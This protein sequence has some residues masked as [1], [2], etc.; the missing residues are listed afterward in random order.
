M[1]WTEADTAARIA[2]PDAFADK[3]RRGVLGAIT[4]GWQISGISTL[5]SGVPVSVGLSGD[6]AAG[7]SRSSRAM[8]AR[9]CRPGRSGQATGPRHPGSTGEVLDVVDR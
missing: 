9:Q 5:S 7:G 2:V 8:V 4:N 1:T 3:H 6:I